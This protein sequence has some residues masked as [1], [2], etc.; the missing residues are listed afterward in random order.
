MAKDNNINILFICT[1]LDIGGNEKQLY[2]VV[3][4]MDKALFNPIVCCLKE[5]GVF[6]KKLRDKGFRVYSNLLK[7]KYDVRVLFSLRSIMKMENIHTVFT[8]GEGD[9]MF[10][11][12]LSAKL[13][14]VPVIIS[15][16]HSTLS[17][18][19][20]GSTLGFLNKLLMPI[21]DRIV[22]V[23]NKQK[24]FLIKHEGITEEKITVIHNGVDLSQFEDQIETKNQK[25]ELGIPSSHSVV[26]IIA[27]LRPEKAHSVFLQAATRILQRIP[28]V[29][30]L[31]IGNGSERVPLENLSKTLGISGNVRFLGERLDIPEILAITDVSVLCSTTIETCPNSILESMAA[32]VPVVTTDVGGLSEIVLDRETGFLVKPGDIQGFA[33]KILWLIKDREKAKELGRAGKERVRKHFSMDIAIH[34]REELI[35]DLTCEK[36][37]IPNP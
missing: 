27:W 5:D 10:W 37:G 15:S 4:G 26:S 16:V 34:S 29:T 14:N 8:V 36:V 2:H 32:E 28:E 33:H 22:A 3:L 25:E 1:V 18:G 23:S 24:E 12:R 21:T 30:F 17:D 6:G 7:S 9:K 13:S 31:I 19:Q 35:L 11:G 20:R